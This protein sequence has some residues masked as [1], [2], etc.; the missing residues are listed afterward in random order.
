MTVVALS[1]GSNMGNRLNNI[2]QAVAMMK[3]L[4]EV[5]N[6]SAVYETPPWG[7]ETQPRFLNACVLLE[8]DSPPKILLDKL[9]EIERA[10]GR[11]ERERWGPREIDV[12]IL[13]YGEEVINEAELTAPHPRMRER[14][15]VLVPLSE[16]A[17]DMKIPPDGCE[18]SRLAREINEKASDDKIVII[19]QL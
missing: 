4:G 12:D 2:R 3:P 11:V 17:P 1:L 13:T 5:T 18:V 6:R 7:I 10:V 8:T 19:T 15:F 14:A 9:K 16:I